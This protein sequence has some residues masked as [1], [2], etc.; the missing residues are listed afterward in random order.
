LAVQN[1][2]KLVEVQEVY[3]NQMTKYDPQS[4]DG[5]LFVEYINTFLK[6]K[7]EA[8]GYPHWVQCH[9][10]EDR[11]F[12]EFY[13]SEGIQLDKG[14]IG[15][16]HAKR[17]L[18]KLCLNSMWSKLRE[19]NNRTRIKMITGPQELYRLLATP[20]IEVAAMVFA[21]DDVGCA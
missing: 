2:Y 12:S 11:Y 13:K 14:N 6:F 20:G 17:G 8:S 18:A 10:D 1:G 4:D 3:E 15:L 5:D 16:G 21:S 7:A 19:S 9:E